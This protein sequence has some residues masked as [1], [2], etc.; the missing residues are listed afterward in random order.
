VAEFWPVSS[1]AHLALII[2]L[3]GW[4][5]PSLSLLVALH[6]GTFVAVAW[7]YRRR[8]LSL[9][10]EGWRLAKGRSGNPAE[11]RLAWLLL[12][13]TLPGVLVGAVSASSSEM[14]EGMPLLMIFL[15]ALFGLVLWIADHYGKERWACLDMGWRGALAVGIAQSVALAPGVSR[16]GACITVARAMGMKRK[17]AADFAF[18]LS[19]PITGAAGAYE[20]L[21]MLRGGSAAGAGSMVAGG[22]AAAVTGYF[23]IRFLL[24]GLKR[25]TFAPYALYRLAVSALLLPFFL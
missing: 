2:H 19:V 21:S 16:S 24:A 17:E 20:A 6:L 5:E 14:M 3:A 15:L 1:S 8:L 23:A 25:N 7:Y 10:R 4:G 18:L 12:L 11:G 9:V 13:A 22:V